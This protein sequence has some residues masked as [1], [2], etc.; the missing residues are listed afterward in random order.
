MA[1][2]MLNIEPEQIKEAFE[3]LPSKDKLKLV[4]VFEKETQ[5]ERWEELLTKIRKRVKAKPIPQKEINRI[6]K[7]VRQELYERRNKGSN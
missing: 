1:K 6:C 4:E 3:K 7:K 5:R 2:V